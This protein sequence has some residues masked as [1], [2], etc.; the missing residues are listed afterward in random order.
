MKYRII[1]AVAFFLLSLPLW[2]IDG[3]NY[4]FHQ[5]SETSYYGGINSVAKDSIGRVWF[6]GTDALYMFNGSSFESKAVSGT[7]PGLQVDYRAIVP[8]LERRLYVATNCGLYGFD[9]L[10]ETMRLLCEG[11]VGAIDTDRTGRVW[12]ILDDVVVRYE[13]EG[14]VRK[15]PL[16]DD[17]RRSPFSLSLLCSGNGVYVGAYGH[18]FT[19]DGDTGA[20]SDFTDVGNDNS[21]ISDVI[22]TEDYVYVLTLRDGLFECDRT[23]HIFR[24][25]KLPDGYD[26]SSTAKKLYRDSDGIIWVATQSGLLLVDPADGETALLTFDLADPLSI[27]NNSVW[28]IYPDPDG[29]V[30]VGTYGGKLAYQS[31]SDNDIRHIAPIPG[32]LPHPIVSAFAEDRLGNLWIGTEGGGV[33]CRSSR[34]GSFSYY[35]QENGCLNSNMVKRIF[36]EGDGVYVSTFNGGLTRIDVRT[37][38]AK[39]LHVLNP[40]SGQPLS[41]YDFLREGN[42][43]WWLSDPDAELMFWNMAS[44]KVENVIFH[45]LDGKKMRMRVE[46]MFH[47]VSGNLWL[48]THSGAYVVDVR[49]RSITGRYAI[50]SGVWSAD[51]LCSWCRTS[52]SELWFGTRGAGVNRLSPDGR[53]VNY[54]SSPDGSFTG[55]TV[56]GIVEDR[57]TGNVWFSTDAGLYTYSRACGEIEKAGIDVPNSCGSWYIRSCFAS[58]T[59]KLLFGGTNGY[60]VFNPSHLNLNRQKPRVWFT[61]LKVNNMAVVPSSKGSALK[62]SV[63]TL[64]G[65]SDRV[66][67]IRLAHNQNDFEV[68]FSSNSYLDPERN[69]YAYRMSGVTNEWTVL[70]PGQHY[71]RFVNLSPGRY[72][73]QLKTANNDGL[74]GDH[75]SSLAFRVKPSPLAS[76]WALTLYLLIFIA[77]LVWLWSWTTRRKMLEQSL[78]ME[79]ERER[80]LQE[81]TKARMDFFTK[82]SHDLKTPLTL[83]IDPLKQLEKT[84]PEDAPNRKYVDTI[85][86]NVGRIQRMIRDLLKFRQIET[87]KLPLKLESGDIV[88]FVDSIFSLFEFCASER[89]IETEFITYTDSYIT[90]FDYD[91]I[92]KVFT[93]LISNA[94]KYT[95]GNGYVSV[96]IARSSAPDG[97]EMVPDGSEWLSFTVTN[98][99]SEIPPEKFDSIFEPFNN[100]GKTRSE[101]ESHTG[102]GLAIVRELVG[103]MKGKISVSSADATVS[104]SVIL[105]FVPCPDGMVDEAAV[106]SDGTTYEYASS[107]IDNM[108]S[109]IYERDIVGE[110]HERKPYNVLVIEDDSSLRNYL[111]QRLSKSYNVYTAMTGDDGI[112]KVEKIMP[113]IVVTDLFMPGA[114]GFE[115][116]RSIR[117]DIKTSHIPIIMLSAA[118]EN[119]NAKI[120]AFENGATVF[121]D[122]PVDID[123]L[124]KQIDNLI[125]RQAL[126]K[127]LYSKKYVAEPSKLTISSMDDELM[128]KAVSFIEQNMENEYYGVDDFVSDMAIGR[129][130][131]YQKITDLTGMSIK[132]FILD[133]RLKRAGQLLRESEYTVAE[134]STMTGFANPKYFSVCFK[135]HFG[136]TPTEFKAAKTGVVQEINKTDN[137]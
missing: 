93:N 14:N 15:Y 80:N 124:L 51:N 133:I 113:H 131:L 3:R 99:G 123:V 101:F 29:G 132:E 21:I 88:K 67:I 8:D 97:V 6:S 12:M 7:R 11:D 134:I 130:R 1:A 38:I 76:P 114:D 74:W 102:L 35:S 115:V 9:Y 42:S 84:I 23:G 118:G 104:F 117:S 135:R 90:R 50:E 110:K 78:E 32:G 49:T 30:W 28:S 92:E 125:K 53:Y 107:E 109:D 37:G 105:P 33:C 96:K 111:E 136:Q 127:N 85:G 22:E 72:K 71:V 64:D 86:R 18:L 2:A 54:N 61:E 31:F 19:L 56:F 137:R 62:Q 87:L 39:D 91:S 59:G 24:T 43:G 98:S 116:C 82:I 26:R 77:A 57:A 63:S 48:V 20:Y 83:V 5:M 44:G 25:F 41:V 129:T 34:D 119:K 81:L 36:C 100:A 68:G 16:P 79:Q 40:S 60:L 46:A 108:I 13:G 65:H 52:D 17:V 55:R 128:R 106:E 112:A 58:S 10:S 70:P 47:D 69:A 27:P 121:M 75:V 126:L 66:H 95:T 120:D 103:D 4:R 89:H 45:D 122:K 73:L 94:V